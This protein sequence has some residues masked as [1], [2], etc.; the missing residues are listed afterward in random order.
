MLY[1]KNTRD[2][3]SY[4]VSP[5]GF[6]MP[7]AAS[8]KS[9]GSEE[10][11][12]TFSSYERRACSVTDNRKFVNKYSHYSARS[13]KLSSITTHRLDRFTE[14]EKNLANTLQSIR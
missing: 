6:L 14:R 8:E 10:D 12:G 9:I 2:P 3:L 13:S 7:I 1:I 5:P 11:S 4:A